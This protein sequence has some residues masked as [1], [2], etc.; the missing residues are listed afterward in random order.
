MTKYPPLAFAEAVS[1][2]ANAA[3]T[4][5]SFLEQV[6][7][8][9]RD[10]LTFWFD[11][12]YVD[13]RKINFHQGQRQAILNIIYL[14]E[15]LGVTTIFEAYSKVAPHL[16]AE[17]D[18]EL[19]RLSSDPTYAH[20][21]YCV[22][23]ATGTGKT[24]V[25][26]ALV[27]WQYLNARHE[28]SDRYTK[29]FLIVA[30]GLIVYDRLLDAFRGRN[31]DNG[32]TRDFE[33][34]DLKRNQQLFIPDEYRDEMFG[35][36]QGSVVEKSDIGTAVTGDGIVA[37]TNYHLLMGVDD[38]K[39]PGDSWSLPVAPGTS[40]GHGLDDL[41]HSLGEKR[42]LEFLRGLPNLIVINDEAHHIHE[43]KKKGEIVE[44]EWQ[45]SLRYI[46]EPKGTHFIQL[47][48]SAT[49]YSQRGKEKVYFPHIVIDFELKTAIQKGLVKTVVLDERK[50]LNTEALDYKVKRDE[51][52]G[53]PLDLSD[54]QRQMLRAGL[55]KLN[56]LE[57]SFST[58]DATKIPKMLI[59]CE[60]TEVVPLV[61]DFLLAEGRD[62]D[63]ILEIHSNKKGEVGQEQWEEMKQ[64]LFAL[65]RHEK[66]R[67]V[68]SVLM[69]REGFDVNNICV[70]VPLRS[71]TSNIL[72]EQTIG[73]GLRLMWRGD[74]KIDE[75]KRENRHR[76]LE[77]KRTATNYFDVLS[78]VEHPAFR[79]FYQQLI[80]EGVVGVDDGDDNGGSTNAKGDLIKSELKPDYEKYDFRIPAIVQEAT[81][82]MKSP[83]F[84]VANLKPYRIP[85]TELQKLVPENEQWISTEVT[86]KTH[87]G[88]FDVVSGVFQATSYND[89]LMRITNR[90]IEKF[91]TPVEKVSKHRSSNDLPA[92]AI[93][94]TAVARLTDTYIRQQLFGEPVDP[95]LPEVWKVL[96]LAP[97]I[98]H[99]S[100]QLS[101]M[102]LKAQEE[103]EVDSEAE[104]IFNALSSVH[105]IMVRE[106]YCLEPVK[107]IY[108]K[109]PYPSN[110]GLY[111]KEFC[112]FCDNDGEVS[113]FCKVQE[114]KHTFLS[115]RYVR[116]DGLPSNYFPDFLVRFDDDIFLV[117]TKAQDNLSNENVQRKQRSA[118]RWAEQINKLP[119]DKREGK[120]WHYAIL[121]DDTFATWKNRGATL[122]DILNFAELR[123]NSVKNSGRLFN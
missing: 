74:S 69:L 114:R 14:Y 62:T 60:D 50:E 28:N 61:R 55:A 81:E 95:S 120:T 42:E 57:G 78:I 16:F 40:A 19:D 118:C 59:M 32:D 44:V 31:E 6:T 108:E 30:P 123:N 29:N 51:V 54:G 76:I 92:I 100:S 88:D 73:R 119:L 27:I 72:L 80:D 25:L 90:V 96:R 58:V 82:I 17:K 4:D 38:A 52:S 20:P 36:L 112:E 68:I 8:T 34:C 7:P 85:L 33:T 2:Q 77:E 115:F 97:I 24:W 45:K 103:T 89:Y 26:E 86:E 35:F 46:A 99:I 41:D 9:T 79:E 98:D 84:D 12:A 121:G 94:Q 53:K 13:L 15:V 48:F 101:E 39:D 105:R 23:M 65:D 11:D 71:T 49:P 116:E 1:S 104:V 70:I 18:V 67:I 3:W 56:L 91:S 102:L 10:L 5:G 93:D 64:Q 122:R 87:F 109:L 66:P 21:K 47:D 107:C 22:K 63:D 110:K 117:E 37:I 106:N 113:A 111:E 43:A 75:L 83:H